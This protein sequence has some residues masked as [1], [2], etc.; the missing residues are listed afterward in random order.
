MQTFQTYRQVLTGEALQTMNQASEAMA[1]S[2]ELITFWGYLIW[3][4]RRFVWGSRTKMMG[5]SVGS[6]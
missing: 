4:A 6:L 2:D 5:L 3:V 1:V